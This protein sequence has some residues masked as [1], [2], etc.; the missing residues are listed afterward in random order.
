MNRRQRERVEDLGR[1]FQDALTD[2]INMGEEELKNN[3]KKL[4]NSYYQLSN[5]EVETIKKIA[6]KI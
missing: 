4:W 6:N 5:E 2:V 3:L 1:S